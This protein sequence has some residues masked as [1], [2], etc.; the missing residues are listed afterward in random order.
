MHAIVAFR[1][2][3]YRLF[4]GIAIFFF[5][6]MLG[7][8]LLQV[9]YRYVLNAPLMW[10]EEL[11]RLMA[12]GTTYFGGVVV[13]IAREHIRV[14]A[15]EAILPARAMAAVTIV[16]DVLIALFLAALAYG[17]LL[18]VQATWTTT[19]ATMDWFRMGYVYAA[20]GFAVTTMIV[21]V[22]LDVVTRLAV[23]AGHEVEEGA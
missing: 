22:L 17:C 21:I 10:T 11:A 19:T 9:F 5:L 1:R 20:V 16:C 2:N 12:V 8:S 7:S 14:D 6:V 18:M 13:L 4:E 15:I 23:I 3:I